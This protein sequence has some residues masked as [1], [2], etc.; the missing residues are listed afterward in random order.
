MRVGFVGVGLM[1]SAMAKRALKDGLE[2]VV[3]DVDSSATAALAEQGAEVAVS[4]R[5]LAERC[6]IAAVVVLN[7]EQAREVVC[8]DLGLL[9]AGQGADRIVIHSTIQL[10]TLYELEEAARS[11]GRILIDAGVSGSVAGAVSGELA[12]MVGGEEEAISSFRPLLET[13]GGLVV[14]VGPLG[15]GM[16]AK[17]ARN[18]ISFGQCAAIYEGMRVAEEAGVDLGS[19]A[20]IVRHS[21]GISGM[22]DGYLS[23]PTVRPAGSDSESDRQRQA[24]AP[25]VISM[26]HK[27]LGA[28]IELGRSLGLDLPV[29]SAARDEAAATW[30]G[31]PGPQT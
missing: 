30:G 18:L 17:V 11:S 3:F 23:M 1:G 21:E 8:G 4:P 29:T 31:E 13:Y 20:E 24:R 7:D 15:S 27:D 22:V 5:E 19:F 25:Y 16:K 9:A 14:R 2:V 26:A 28:A 12:V 10:P 6:E